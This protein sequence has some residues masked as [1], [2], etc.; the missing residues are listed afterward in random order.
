MKKVALT[1]AVLA[2]G[3][4]ACEDNAPD[5]EASTVNTI[6]MEANADT[7]AAANSVDN[8]LDATENAADN[9][10]VTDDEAAANNTATNNA[11]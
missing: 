11:M 6:E 1:V 8:A 3:L 5:N 2:L 10:V 4:A 7:A 9:A